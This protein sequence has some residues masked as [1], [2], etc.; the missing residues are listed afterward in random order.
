MLQLLEHIAASRSR[1]SVK[2]EETLPIQTYYRKDG[3]KLYD[4]RKSMHESLVGLIE[5]IRGEA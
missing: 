2:L 4:K 5:S 1:G 3:T